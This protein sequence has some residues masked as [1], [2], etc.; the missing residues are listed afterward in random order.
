[1]C[2][3]A[4][5]R[6]PAGIA[7][8]TDNTPGITRHASAAESRPRDVGRARD[9]QAVDQLLA[10]QQGGHRRRTDHQP[11]GV[12]ISTLGSAA[13]AALRYASAED[14]SMSAR[15]VQVALGQLFEGGGR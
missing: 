15:R 7:A 12:A 2:T 9:V 11:L 1:M 10:E 14:S 5:R 13:V 8:Q 4:A 3:P 6:G